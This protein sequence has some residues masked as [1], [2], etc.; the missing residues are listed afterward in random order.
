MLRV[1][2]SEIKFFD[3]DT[4]SC[5]SNL[6]LL[7]WQDKQALDFSLNMPHFNATPAVGRLLHFIRDEKPYFQPGIILPS[8]LRRVLC[9]K[10]KFNSKR[11]LAQAGAFLLF[12]ATGEL[13]TNPTPGIT[14]DRIKINGNKK[15]D[16]IEELDRVGINES[17][18]FP[19]IESAAKYISKKF[20]R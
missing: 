7:T 15:M 14:V 12:G 9:I 1:K 17:T 13:D 4:A 20:G 8:D 10:T 2:H 11:I 3:S 5:I 6:S 16:L 19:E 18:M